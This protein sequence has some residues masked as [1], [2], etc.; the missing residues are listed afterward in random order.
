[1]SDIAT[2]VDTEVVSNTNMT[3]SSVP[4]TEK[5]LDENFC[6]E[7]IFYV[8]DVPEIVEVKPEEEKK[9]TKKTTKRAPRARGFMLTINNP[10]KDDFRKIEEENTVCTR[11]QLE[12]GEN[13]T[14][15]IQAYL[16]YKNAVVWPK[17]KFPTAHIEQARNQGDA[18]EYCEKSLSREIGP[19]AW[20]YKRGDIPRQGRR[21]D[22]EQ[23]AKEYVDTPKKKD[24]CVKNPAEYVKY[25][26]GLQELKNT[27][28]LVPRS[29]K[30]PPLI[31]WIY[32]L[33]GVGKTYFPHRFF[34][35][36]DIYIKDGTMWWNNYEQQKCIIIDDFDGK[37]PYR[38]LLRLLDKYKYQGQFKGGYVDINSKFIFITCEFPPENFWSGN[39]LKQI[40]RRLLT[41][42]AYNI[43][44]DIE[45]L[46]TLMKNYEEYHTYK[47]D[48]GVIPDTV[49]EV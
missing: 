32:G 25:Y 20:S 36:E 7:E 48:L 35:E 39:E 11:A 43:P 37:W 10:T 45:L 1:M 38:D 27:I 29:L 24:F 4:E 9:T 40:K 46:E 42:N 44:N 33:S 19:D 14:L 13:G 18:A 6:G 47:S 2:H 12:R 31:F 15:H 26:R 17:D 8:P 22:L 5:N 3:T 30:D 21:K 41:E 28:K 34:N 23:I 49:S 16:Y